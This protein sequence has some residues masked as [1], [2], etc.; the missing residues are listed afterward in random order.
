TIFVIAITL[1]LL[2]ADAREEYL[3]SLEH[4][5]WGRKI[6]SAIGYT[7]RPMIIYTFIAVIERRKWH[8]LVL[9]LITV[10]NFVLEVSSI[11]TG[12]VFFYHDDNNHFGRGPLGYLA[13]IV[14]AIY[15]IY[16]LLITTKTL[17]KGKKES[18]LL[19][20]SFIFG[21][22]G[23]ILEH[24]TDINLLNLSILLSYLLYYMYIFIQ[25]TREYTDQQKEVIRNQNNMLL[26][27]QITPHF[28][29]NALGTIRALCDVDAKLAGKTIEDFSAYL[30]GNID[31][32]SYKEPIPFNRELS[33]A[34]AYAQIEMLRFD[35][36]T[37]S[38]EIEDENFKLPALTVQPL[39]ENA[40]KH[41]VRSKD[42]GHITVR[43]RLEGDYHVLEVEDDGVGFDLSQINK[44]DGR[45]HVG[46]TNVKER[47]EKMMKGSL[48]VESEMGVGTKIII[49]IPAK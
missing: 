14:S 23:A 18:A 13:F 27:S 24:E 28:M 30:R 29:F 44:D 46:F 7:L 36:I 39:V 8:L 40:I 38:Y 49:K 5:T 32:I 26:T 42:E 48:K 43:T 33:H 2:I 11:W 47:I 19:F 20:T 45:A 3:A 17:G 35:Y 9:R 25:R 15:L 37:V 22:L 41:G 31:S 10:V 12:I 6:C 34:K 1:V 21:T 16:G 4:P